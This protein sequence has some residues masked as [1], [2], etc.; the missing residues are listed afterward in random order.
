M[1]DGIP[2]VRQARYRL[3]G[4]Q[5]VP[6][7][8][9][10]IIRRGNTRL[11]VRGE[12]AG[13]LLDLLVAR[14]AEGGGIGL[15]EMKAETDPS[16]HQVLASLIKQLTAARLLVPSGDGRRILGERRE[17]VFYWNHGTTLEATATNIEQVSLVVFGVNHVALPL[18][19]NLRSCGFRSLT[20]VDHPALRNLD[21][22]TDRQE[23]R[24]EIAAA[25]SVKP[26]QFEEWQQRSEPPDGQIVCSD[27]GGLALMRD[28]NRACVAARVLFYPIVLQDEVA[29]L[30]PLVVPGEGPCFECLWNR[31]NANLAS[32]DLERAPEAHAFFGQAV[33]GYLRPMARVAADIAAIELLKFFGR[34]LPGGAAGRLIEADLMAPTLRT[35][36]VLKVPRC[37]VCSPAAMPAGP[38]DETLR[39]N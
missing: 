17:D 8:G 19:G 18:L 26:R 4:L 9:G 21:F 13:E 3:L 30:G 35:R 38:G 28:W 12:K 20:L 34:T 27:F 10:V 22:F 29:Y 33:S 24:P 36:N 32:P 37:P 5:A 6:Y 1:D 25:M 39:G 15:E 14:S 31:Q 11:V 2:G 23:L 7:D 16:R